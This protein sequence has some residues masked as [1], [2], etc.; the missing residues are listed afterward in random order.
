MRLCRAVEEIRLVARRIERTVKLGPV[1]AFDAA[2]IVPGGEAIGPQLARHPQQIGELGPH[3]AAYA[4]HRGAAGEIVIGEP[5]DHVLAKDALVIEHVMRDAQPVGHAPRVA[6]VV[7]RAARSLAPR[8][9]AVVV[10]LEGDSDDL[11]A[12]CLGER[13]DDRRID[14][15]RHRHH[16]AAV[17]RGARQVEQRGGRDC[18]GRDGKGN[19]GVHGGGAHTPAAARMPEMVAAMS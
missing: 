12:C 1:R 17:L 2:D 15:A 16:D 5:L 8:R 10:E 3:V 6:N 14:P 19:W 13:G 7:A 11:G 4:R 9:G 18:V